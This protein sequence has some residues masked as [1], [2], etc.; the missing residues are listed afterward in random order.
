MNASYNPVLTDFGLSR[1]ALSSGCTTTE[2]SGGT[3]C[4]MAPELFDPTHEHH[5]DGAPSRHS[6]IFALVILWWEV[7]ELPDMLTGV[8]KR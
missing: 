8:L 4:Y 2:T 5:N 6:D 3:Y 1:A 7:Q